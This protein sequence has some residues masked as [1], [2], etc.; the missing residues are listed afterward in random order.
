M[1]TSTL[2]A[3]TEDERTMALL[4]HVLMIVTWWI[5][6]LIIYL[7]KRDSRFVAFHALQ[8]LF[9]QVALFLLWIGAFGLF[10]VFAFTEAAGGKSGGPP[11]AFMLAFFLLWLVMMVAWVLTLVLGIV[12]GIKA[13]KGEWAAYPVVGRWARR[14]AGV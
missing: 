4:A 3:P 2:P 13:S 12:Y 14:L 10:F 11:A 6:P 1:E 9:W 8:A 5:G 7:L